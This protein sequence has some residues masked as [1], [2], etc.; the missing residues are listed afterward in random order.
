MQNKLFPK[1]SN[2]LI[3]VVS[4]AEVGVAEADL[5]EEDAVGLVEVGVAGVDLD[6][7]VEV[8]VGRMEGV[9]VGV[10]GDTVQGNGDHVVA[11]NRKSIL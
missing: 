5:G 9:E 10:V 6:V 8:G 3:V 11:V 4:E 1:N 2:D 7:E